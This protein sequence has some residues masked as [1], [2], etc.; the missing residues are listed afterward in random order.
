MCNRI[1]TEK[2][3]SGACIIRLRTDHGENASF[4]EY[5][6]EKGI[7]HEF[8]IAAQQNGKK[9][10]FLELVNAK[11]AQHFWAEAIFMLYC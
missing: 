11:I 2:D 9:R 5:C 6:N 4:A 1:Q 7:K 10:V 3:A 8:S